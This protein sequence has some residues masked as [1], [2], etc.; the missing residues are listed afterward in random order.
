MILALALAVFF[1]LVLA[2][3]T[4]NTL[5]SLGLWIGRRLG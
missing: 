4:I 3:V 1:T 2:A 5:W